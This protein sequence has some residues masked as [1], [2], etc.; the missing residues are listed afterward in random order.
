M[1]GQ[2]ASFA[3]YTNYVRGLNGLIVDIAN[4]SG[5]ITAADFQLATWKG[6]SVGGFTPLAAV[7]TITTIAGGGIANTTRIKIEF[8]DNAIRNTWLRVTL[9][10]NA[11]TG[12]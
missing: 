2:V 11:N 12:L 6:I 8:A 5:T 1:P 9:L 3:N 10:A 7:P 4:P